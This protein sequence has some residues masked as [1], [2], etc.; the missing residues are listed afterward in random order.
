MKNC[1]VLALMIIYVLF[2]GCASAGGGAAPEAGANLIRNGD[3]ARFSNEWPNLPSNWTTTWKGGDG[4]EPIKTEDGRFIGWAENIYS[5]TLSQNITG[6]TEGVYSLSAEFRLNPDSIVE[7]IVMNVYSGSTLVKSMS[8]VADLLAAPRE[9]DLLF[10]MTGIE[11]T[12][13]SAKVE[14]AGT[15][16]LKNIGIDNVVFT[17]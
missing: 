13:R 10:E 2:S 17:R 8:V 4:Y 11:I 12:G 6:L 16:I 9:T 15:K 5:F 3:F 14:F 7:D 1:L